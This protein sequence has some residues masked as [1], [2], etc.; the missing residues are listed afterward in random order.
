MG[1][2]REP[3]FPLRTAD[4]QTENKPVQRILPGRE[5]AS[6]VQALLSPAANR[7]NTR[8]AWATVASGSVAV[9]AGGRRAN[10]GVVR[11]WRARWG[12]AAARARV[13]LLIKIYK[14]IKKQRLASVGC[15][16]HQGAL[17][18]PPRPGVHVPPS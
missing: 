6:R 5:F 12:A 11:L 10:A 8:A 9:A 7:I 16:A 2:K 17:P 13:G 1:S 15:S 4:R 3:G 18:P 14:L